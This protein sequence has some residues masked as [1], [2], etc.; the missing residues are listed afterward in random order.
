MKQLKLAMLAMTAFLTFSNV[1]AQDESNPW[2]V[3]FGINTVDFTPFGTDDIG[4]IV[5]DYV[6]VTEWGD[7]TLPSISRISVDRY[8]DKGFSVQFAG[9]INKVKTYISEED[10]DE[11]YWSIDLAAKYDLNSLIGDTAWF[12]P[13]LAIGVSYAD[14]GHNTQL[15]NTSTFNEDLASLIHFLERI[16][17]KYENRLSSDLKPFVQGVSFKYSFNA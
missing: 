15:L 8:I 13:Y 17:K 11:L 5:K 12:D 14:F 4:N 10:T 1:S 7:N 3:G 16:P 2:A 9:S 6:G